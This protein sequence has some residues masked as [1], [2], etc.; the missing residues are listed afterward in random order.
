[1]LPAGPLTA[2]ALASAVPAEARLLTVRLTGAVIGT[3]VE[4]LLA[5]SAP[6]CQISGLMVE[7]D[8]RARAYD[9]VKR[10]RTI[11]GLELDRKKSYTVALSTNLLAGD[12][13]PLAAGDCQAGKGCRTPA[14][15]DALGVVRSDVRVI[16][17]VR[18]YLHRLPQPVVPPEDLRLVP[19]H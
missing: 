15:L 4:N 6:C 12:A 11:R 18:D 9:R 7:F 13:L 3:L 1:V 5:D 14:A 16:D 2:A 19:R 8:P 10:L 17:A